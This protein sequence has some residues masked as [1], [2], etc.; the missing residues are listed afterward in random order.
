MARGLCCEDL[1]A[2]RLDQMRL[3]EAHAA[4]DEERVVRRRMVGDLQAGG[5]GELVRLAGHER[6]ERE[7]AVQAAG[8]DAARRIGAKRRDRGGG[9]GRTVA[10]PKDGRRERRVRR[11]RRTGL[12]R[13]GR[14]GSGAGLCSQ[15]PGA[16]I[17]DG[18][19]DGNRFAGCLARERFNA[20][21]EAVF[22]PLQ[23]EAVR[24]GET[25]PS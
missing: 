23:H 10:R 19:L 13:G 12:A 21:A 18:E 6:A 4:V 1:V 9:G 16:G 15:D 22:H 7:R 2:D 3:A 8:L 5:A 17:G 20:A 25:K 11:G 14:R 24:R